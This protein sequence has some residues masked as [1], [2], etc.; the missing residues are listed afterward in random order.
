MSGRYYMII[1]IIILRAICTYTHGNTL[2]HILKDNKIP[3]HIFGRIL[4]ACGYLNVECIYKK[5]R[6]LLPWDRSTCH[7]RLS[8]NFVVDFRIIWHWSHSRQ[9]VSVIKKRCLKRVRWTSIKPKGHNYILCI[10][11]VPFYFSQ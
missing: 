1:I 9:Y 8:C 6:V 7:R 3:T 2:I 5:L 4:N 11:R 10:E